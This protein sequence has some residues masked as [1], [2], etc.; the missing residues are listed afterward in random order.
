MTKVSVYIER[1][2]VIAAAATHFE[3][4]RGKLFLIDIDAR[5]SF[6]AGRLDAELRHEVN[7]DVFQGLN[8]PLDADVVAA[9]IQDRIDH[10][11][12]RPV[13]G[14]LTA[15]VRANDRIHRMA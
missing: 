14:D 1:E 2:A 4:N 7:H 13:P 11:L 10:Q 6:S 3:P 5:G 12:P 8:H 15:T 9:K